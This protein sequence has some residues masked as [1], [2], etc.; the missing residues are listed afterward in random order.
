MPDQFPKRGAIPSPPSVL[1]AAPRHVALVGAPPNLIVIPQKI[2]FSGEL[3]QRRLRH[4]KK[5]SPRHATILRY[6][7]R[8]T[9]L[10][11]GRRNMAY[12]NGASNTQVMTWMQNDGFPD[13][14]LTYDDGPYDVDFTNAGTLQSAIS[15]GPVK[16]GIAG[17]QIE[18]AWGRQDATGGRSG[19]FARDITA[20]PPT[21]T[22]SRCA[23]MDPYPGW[24]SSWASRCPQEST[25]RRRAMR[26][27][28]GIP[29]GSSTC[30]P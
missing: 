11:R 26:C 2:S 18:T 16:L 27:S 5:H 28:R 9:R 13:G 6:S 4:T 25:G 20:T 12:S 24:H 3:R 10:S 30:P 22:P 14:P 15:Q 21:I 17:D 8:M 23:A 19:W 1:A 29:L 7:S